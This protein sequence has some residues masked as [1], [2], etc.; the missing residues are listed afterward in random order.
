MVKL[1]KAPLEVKVE[2]QKKEVD[3]KWYIFLYLEKNS[4]NI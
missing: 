1:H 4:S 3:L 2:N